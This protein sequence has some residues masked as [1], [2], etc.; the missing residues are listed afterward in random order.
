MPSPPTAAALIERL[1]FL[2]PQLNAGNEDAKREALILSRILTICLNGPLNTALEIT[3]TAIDL[4]LFE[5]L[6]ARNGPITTAE[7][8]TLSGGEEL[9]I[10]RVFRLLASTGFLAEVDEQT[11][12][13]TPV[14]QAMTIK[15]IAAGHRMIWELIMQGALK[16]PKFLK[17]TGYKCPEN[18]NDGLVQYAFQTKL[19]TFQIIAS[20]PELLSDFNTFMGSTMGTRKFWLHWYPVQE[21]ILNG[22]SPGT[23]LIVDVGAG[24]GHDLIEFNAKFP[25]HRLVLQ[26]LP[27]V[28]DNLPVLDQAIESCVYDFFTEQ[29]LKGSRVYFYHHILHDWSDYK[30]LEILSGLKSA[31]KP[32]Y[33]LLLLHEMIVPEKGA[34]AF[35]ALL[36]LNMMALNSGMER[37]GKQFTALLNKAGFEVIKIWLPESDPDANGIVE[38]MIKV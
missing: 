10:M 35:H 29:P 38:A 7:L 11:W 4:N 33:S 6:V 25:G 26:D 32:G 23:P 17:E 18:P 34:T 31:M 20:N 21:R 2:K 27:Q 3:V 28:V 14:S 5:F 13:A 16:A 19:Q 30:C 1:D 36:D 9:L 37:T 22:A 8:A 12:V 24:K 15:E